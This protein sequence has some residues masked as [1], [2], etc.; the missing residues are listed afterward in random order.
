LQVLTDSQYLPTA[1][2]VVT[3]ATLNFPPA[4]SLILALR[5]RSTPQQFQA[6]QSFSLILLGATLSTLATL[7]F[8]LAL[9]VSVLAAPLAFVRRSSNAALVAPQLAFLAALS[10]PVAFYA[11]NRFYEG[12]G[13]EVVLHELAKG[14]VA[15]GVWT[16]WVVWGVW[17]PAWTVGATVVCSGLWK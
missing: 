15:Q 9:V 6:L 4:L 5:L 12:R 14:W 1:L 11:L 17:W 16:E 2:Q 3:G 10:P 8:S 13:L 7:N